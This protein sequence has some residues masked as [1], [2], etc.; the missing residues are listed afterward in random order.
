MAEEEESSSPSPTLSDVSPPSSINSEGTG[1]GYFDLY[2]PFTYGDTVATRKN[3]VRIQQ[4]IYTKTRERFISKFVPYETREERIVIENEIKF[5]SSLLRGCQNILQFK[6]VFEVHKGTQIICELCEGGKLLKKVLEMGDQYSEK[7]AADI[8]KKIAGILSTLQEKKVIHRDFSTDS[9][10]FSSKEEDLKALDFGVAIQLKEAGDTC[11]GRY[12]SVP[13]LAPEMVNPESEHGLEADIWSAGVILCVLLTGAPPFTE[14]VNEELALEEIKQF[15]ID[16]SSDD[17]WGHVSSDAR[18]LISE[19]LKQDPKQRISAANILNHPW[20]RQGNEI[21]E[22]PMPTSVM[23]R[24]ARFRV[25]YAE[26]RVNLRTIMETLSMEEKQGLKEMFNHTAD[27]DNKI[28]VENLTS[29]LNEWG[30][31]LRWKPQF[32]LSDVQSFFRRMDGAISYE[33]FVWKINKQH[34]K[35]IMYTI[36]E[37]EIARLKEMTMDTADKDY[38]ITLENLTLVINEWGLKLNSKPQFSLSEVQDFVEK[39]EGAISYEEFVSKLR[40]E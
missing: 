4:V 6:D 10:L 33:E 19:M 5:L 31:K 13:Y 3:G 17:I 14:D 2:I 35:A 32:N 39:W 30:L 34:L 9:F 20:I 15:K 23:R 1:G 22:N 7:V 16:F 26:Q 28:T 18:N 21:C 40:K 37:K 36:S 27:K 24:M 11:K 29:A 12:G 38:K 25:Y 8:F